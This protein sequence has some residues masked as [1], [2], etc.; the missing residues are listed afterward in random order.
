MSDDV[1]VAPVESDTTD[2]NEGDSLLTG[3]TPEES[4]PEGEGNDDQTTPEGEDSKS[5]SEF[6][7]DGFNE[8]IAAAKSALDKFGTP[9]LTKL[10]DD[11]GVGN[12]PE[13]IRFMVR[14]GRQTMEDVPG[15]GA[16]QGDSKSAV[17]VLYPT[18]S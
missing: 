14:V 1:Q 10:M 2:T 9:E 6:G 8:N 15:G 7:G 13:M 12:H 4:T 18:Q 17:D 3:E 16:P 11:F 5:D